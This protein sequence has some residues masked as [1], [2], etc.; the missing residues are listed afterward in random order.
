MPLPRNPSP[1]PRSWASSSTLV[2]ARGKRQ[3]A[4]RGVASRSGRPRASSTR[5]RKVQKASSSQS[6]RRRGWKVQ[7]LDPTSSASSTGSSPPST[8]LS[9]PKARGA[10]S[11]TMKKSRW[12]SLG[13]AQPRTLS[14][15]ASPWLSL[16]SIQRSARARSMARSMAWAVFLA[17][18]GVSSVAGGS[19]PV[20]AAWP[21]SDGPRSSQRWRRRCRARN[22]RPRASSRQ[23]MAAQVSSG[24]A[25]MITGR[26]TWQRLELA[27]AACPGGQAGAALSR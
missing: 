19:D 7:R 2:T 16:S 22:Q 5:L 10:S 26:P 8:S 4:R 25:G 3:L 15:R 20:A 13:S 23:A 27:R 17:M 18:G 21:A 12:M 1:S 11:R 6:S 24:M 14:Q 9:A